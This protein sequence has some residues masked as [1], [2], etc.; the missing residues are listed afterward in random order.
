MLKFVGRIL[1]YAPDLTPESE[2]EPAYF[3]K[4]VS[5]VETGTRRS[6]EGDLEIFIFL[7]PLWWLVRNIS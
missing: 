2:I 1:V 3:P 5:H 7:S 6:R 4:T